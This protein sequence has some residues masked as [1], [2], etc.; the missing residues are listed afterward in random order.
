MPPGHPPMIRYDL[1][2]KNGHAFDSWFASASAYDTLERSGQLSCAVCGDTRIHKALMAPSVSEGAKQPARRLS[3]PGNPLEKAM[4]ELRRKVEA[5]SDYV[6]DA[7]AR[8]ARA[9]HEGEA[10]AKPV[11]GETTLEE[12]KEL[13][14]DGVSAVP[15]PAAA[16]P[17]KPVD[18]KKL[19]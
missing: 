3:E 19:N 15:L 17:A 16:T 9:M 11:W 4:A 6:G 8:E 1:T 7:F 12:A 18:Q 2:C 5:G 13:I 10:E 14:E